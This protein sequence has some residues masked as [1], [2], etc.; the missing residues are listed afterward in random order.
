MVL[1]LLLL[2]LLLSINI[3]N[4]ICAVLLRLTIVVNNFIKICLYASNVLTPKQQQL[5]LTFREMPKRHATT[6]CKLLGCL[7]A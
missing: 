7:A 2:L 3:Y 6:C 5:Q 1:L 4:V